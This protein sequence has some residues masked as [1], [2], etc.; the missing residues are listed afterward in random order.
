MGGKKKIFFFG[1]ATLCFAGLILAG[2]GV[3]CALGVNQAVGVLCAMALGV[4]LLWWAY[5]MFGW[6]WM[7]YRIERA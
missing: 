6:K 5:D 1:I 7:D 3:C 4:S 2:F